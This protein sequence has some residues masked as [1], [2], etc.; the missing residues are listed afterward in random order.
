MS[1]RSE[2]AAARVSAKR[3][4]LLDTAWSL[5]CRNGFRAVGIDTVLAEAG[6]AK[7]TLYKHFASKDD[8]IAATLEK[9]SA[10]IIAGIDGTVAAAGTDPIQRL[11]AVFDWVATWFASEG[12]SGCAFMKAV[13]EFNHAG[14][15][16]RQ[17]AA[18]YKLALESRVQTLCREAKLNSPDR[19]AKQLMVIIDGATLHA[20]MHH[21][22]SYAAEARAAAKTLVEA[23]RS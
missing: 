17:A 14:D 15:K 19:L 10:A 22:A 12:F 16:P 23:A 5:F 18:A 7:M 2:S 13:G 4:H 3:E 6:V 9:Q 11:F 20:L 21:D 1:T 8:L